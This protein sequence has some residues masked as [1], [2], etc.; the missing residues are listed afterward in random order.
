MPFTKQQTLIIKTVFEMLGMSSPVT[1]YSIAQ[2]LNINTSTVYNQIN[3]IK[4]MEV[5]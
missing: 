2:R 4:N 1:G 5:L 3:K